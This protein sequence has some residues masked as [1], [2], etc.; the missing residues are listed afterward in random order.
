MSFL[1]EEENLDLDFDAG[2]EGDDIYE[3]D[4]VDMGELEESYCEFI[5]SCA[6]LNEAAMIQE[7]KLLRESA[8]EAEVLEEGVVDT[9][10]TW[11]KKFVDFCKRMWAKITA[12]FSRVWDKIR[13]LFIS[14]EKWLEENAKTLASVDFKPFKMK[15]YAKV[16][17]GKLSED[18][19]SISEV[20]NAIASLDLE[21]IVQVD[22]AKFFA[23]GVK[24]DKVKNVLGNKKEVSITPAVVKSIAADMPKVI[25]AGKTIKNLAGPLNKIIKI[26]EKVVEK[27]SQWV[28]ESKL[29][30][31]KKAASMAKQA[32]KGI[33]KQLALAKESFGKVTTL[34]NGYRSHGMKVL[35]AAVHQP[36][37]KKESGEFAFSFTE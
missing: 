4:D 13:N 10:K 14:D 28:E 26:S 19:K 1:F 29:G 7:A 21:A 37:G 25:T 16:G 12:F 34:M 6:A 5:T 30:K 3:T 32:A 17:Q 31:N 8:G 11:W 33:N 9:L 35:H 22:S 24:L 36:S 15:V 2:A 27:G 18:V 20:V 23:A